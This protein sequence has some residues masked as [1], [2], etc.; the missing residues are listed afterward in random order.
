MPMQYGDRDRIQELVS[1]VPH[2]VRMLAESLEN[3]RASELQNYVQNGIPEQWM[4]PAD[5]RMEST[6]SRLQHVLKCLQG[7]G[8]FG[9]HLGP[10]CAI[11]IPK[12]EPNVVVENLFREIASP[13]ITDNKLRNTASPQMCALEDLE[14]GKR[15]LYSLIFVGKSLHFIVICEQITYCF[16]S[17]GL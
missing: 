11:M 10:E 1:I 3:G 6:S 5:Q 2:G 7:V 13:H 12:P 8:P 17:P 4:V 16:Q 14:F 15:F 9:H